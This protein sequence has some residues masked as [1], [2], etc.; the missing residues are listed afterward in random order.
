MNMDNFKSYEF[1]F[2]YLINKCILL[3][4]YIDNNYQ[5]DILHDIKIF[6][7]KLQNIFSTIDFKNNTDKKNKILEVLINYF[8]KIIDNKIYI[9]INNVNKNVIISEVE[10]NALLLCENYE[11]KNINKKNCEVNNHHDNMKKFDANINV[12]PD[13]LPNNISSNILPSSNNDLTILEKKINIKIKLIFDEIETNIK[14]S[15]KNYFEHTQHIEY[16]LDKKFNNKI[17]NNNIFIENKVKDILKEVLNTTNLN[18]LT[19][20]NELIKNQINDIYFYI[21]NSIKD[22]I[23]SEIEYKIKILGDIFNNNIHEIFNKLDKKIMD[24]EGELFKMLEN[25]INNSNFNKHNFNIIF[26]KDNNEIKLFYCNDIITSAKINIKGLI[27]PKGPPGNKGDNGITPIIR[28]I[29]F[30]E[31]D[32]LK[33]IFQEGN[34]IYEVISDNSVPLGPKGDQG[35]RGEPGKSTLDL[36]WNQ[37]NVMRIDEDNKDSIIFLKSLCIGDKSHCLNNNSFALGGALC[38]K[39]DSFGIGSNSKTLDSESIALFGTCIGKKSFSYR[40]DNV[41]ENTIEFGKKE[42]SNYNINSFNIVS[43]EINLDCDVLKIKTNKYENN[44]LKDLEDKIISLEKKIVDI[45]KKI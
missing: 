7:N 19:N 31:N 10:K 40:A 23:A 13:I 41:D 12:L 20:T 30:I 39:N 28:K 34:N 38:Y 37:E 11:K 4:K 17:D 21:N 33:F 14:S 25:K 43:K 15:L 22:N 16:D 42:R 9:L 35:I 6:I 27:G 45:Y 24:N 44:K 26:D 36:K 18:N 8:E 29:Q 5:K 2:L 32:K 3:F 1:T